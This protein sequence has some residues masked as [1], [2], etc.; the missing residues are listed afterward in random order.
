MAITTNAHGGTI[1]G[2]LDDEGKNSKEAKMTT[3]SRKST[4]DSN[5]GT[6]NTKAQA[7]T[8]LQRLRQ[9]GMNVI[10]NIDGQ[11]EGKIII[12]GY[13]FTLGCFNTAKY[14]VSTRILLD[15][16]LMRFSE[17]L[18]FGRGATPETVFKTSTVTV[19]LDE[20]MAMRGLKDKKNARI[21]F[22]ETA[23]TLLN[24]GMRFDYTIKHRKGRKTI[25]ERARVD[26]YL[27]ITT[28]SIR[29]GDEDPLRNSRITFR[30]NYDFVYYLCNR[31]IMPVDVK[32]F[33][34]NPH[35]NPHSYNIMRKLTEHYD[36]NATKKNEPV[37][38]SVRA[39]LEYCPEL[40]NLDEVNDRHQ[41]QLIMKPIDR[42]LNALE[43][44]YSLIKHQ[45]SHSK[46][47][48]LTDDELEKMPFATWLDLMIE[49]Y[50]PDYPVETAKR[51]R[52]LQ[53]E[54]AQQEDTVIIP[55]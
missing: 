9:R 51:V 35:K 12:N 7:I 4:A 14:N 13:E 1:T 30:I 24:V 25:E 10:I 39:I 50:L 46:G 52:K 37:R 2:R 43:D 41:A 34:I 18:P 28:I 55:A 42:D 23:H 40:L 21:Q 3:N 29:T 26:G 31:S 16:L 54:E 33:A 36:Y 6:Y 15:Y 44:T 38:I 19:T 45:Y 22:R 11:Q 17:I 49:Y 8:E 47:K 27:F 48:T 53:N 32:M 20:F 5:A